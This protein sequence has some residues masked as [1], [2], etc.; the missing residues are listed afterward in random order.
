MAKTVKL[1][2]IGCGGMANIHATNISK[3]GNVEVIGWCDVVKDRAN[4]FL[5]KYGGKYATDKSQD[6]LNDPDIDGVFIIT[7]RNDDPGYMHAELGVRAIEAG[8]HIF[9]EKPIASTL[10]SADRLVEAMSKSNIKFQHGFC[11]EY[12]PTIERAK[13]LMPNPAYSVCQ[14]AATLSGQSCHNIDVIVHKFHDAPLVSVF[15]SGGKYFGFDKQLPIDSFSAVFKFADGSTSSYV[16]H[17]TMN[18]K[19]N[20]FQIQLFGPEGCVFLG[21]RFRDVLWYPAD[22]SETE[23]YRDEIMYMGHFQEVEDFINCII[24]DRKPVNTAEKGRYVL[25]IE[26]AIIQSAVTGKVIDKF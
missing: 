3:I 25:A 11:F 15:A 4:G 13:K 23:P 14:C 6:I 18:N 12:S 20:K 5:N 22:G 19:L 2:F 17:G 10:E 24:D 26:K 21:D 16:Q 9:V 8:K 1:G 7:S